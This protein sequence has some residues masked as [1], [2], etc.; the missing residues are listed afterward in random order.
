MCE[1]LKGKTMNESNPTVEFLI[2]LRKIDK[3]GITLRDTLML[4]MVIGNPGITG[5]DLGKAVGFGHRSSVDS[6]I[7]RLIRL[8][9][10]EDR[11]ERFGQAIPNDLHITSKGMEFWNSIKP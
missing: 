2:R 5:L 3:Q 10:I 6:N 1:A 8:G 7:R 11:R 4:Y 9:L